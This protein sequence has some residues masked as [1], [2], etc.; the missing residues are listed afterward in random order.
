MVIMTDTELSLVRARLAANPDIL[1][2]PDVAK[3]LLFTAEYYRDFTQQV[4]PWF[5]AQAII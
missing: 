4:A 2:D 3:R 5:P 1:I